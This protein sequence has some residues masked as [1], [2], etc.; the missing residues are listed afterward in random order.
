MKTKKQ[1]TITIETH[2]VT[3][4]RFK[5]GRSFI[6]FD[7][8]QRNT[9]HLSVVRAVS[10]LSL[11]ETEIYRLAESKQ[12]RYLETETGELLICGNSFLTKNKKQ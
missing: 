10:V 11:G 4:I 8:C 9:L 7:E 3:I 1:Q 2:E 12:I 6:S 5:H